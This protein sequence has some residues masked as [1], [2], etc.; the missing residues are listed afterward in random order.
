MIPRNVNYCTKI[1]TRAHARVHTKRRVERERERVCVCV[2]NHTVNT[3]RN[4]QKHHTTTE[5][6]IKENLFPHNK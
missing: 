1:N 5:L 4:I 6:K 3:K 2:F